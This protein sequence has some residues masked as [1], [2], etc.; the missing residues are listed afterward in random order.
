MARLF[1]FS[2]RDEKFKASINHPTHNVFGLT[3]VWQ[4]F[5][6]HP[7]INL[8]DQISR[9][10]FSRKTFTNHSTRIA[11]F[12]FLSHLFTAFPRWAGKAFESFRI[13]VK[14]WSL[15]CWYLSLSSFRV[16]AVADEG[17][18]TWMWRGTAWTCCRT[19]QTQLRRWLRQEGPLFRRRANSSAWE[20][21]WGKKKVLSLIL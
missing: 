9:R 18:G 16:F 8:V 1:S 4:D 14:H 21:F 20:N 17:K 11:S 13:L 2:D 15:C 6:F 12:T 10:N 3:K 5:F 7:I 19:K